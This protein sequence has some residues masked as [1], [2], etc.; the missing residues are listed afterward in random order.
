MRNIAIV[1]AFIFCLLLKYFPK[2][3]IWTKNLLVKFLYMATVLGMGG[4]AAL[5]YIKY[6]L[7]SKAHSKLE[8][9]KKRVEKFEIPKLE[10]LYPEG[11]RAGS[12]AGELKKIKAV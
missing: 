10:G 12:V 1:Q 6:K 4:T 11:S 9:R 7:Y 3:R 8:S 2:V 5:G